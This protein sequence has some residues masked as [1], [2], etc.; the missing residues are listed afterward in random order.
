MDVLKESFDSE[1]SED[2]NYYLKIL[3]LYI[4]LFSSKY[5]DFD[6]INE[7]TCAPFKSITTNLLFS[8]MIATVLNANYEID[9]DENELSTETRQLT[10]YKEDRAFIKKI[11]AQYLSYALDKFKEST[12]YQGAHSLFELILD[13]LAT[14]YYNEFS[15]QRIHPINLMDS[16]ISANILRFESRLYDT[17][18]KLENE[19]N[20]KLKLSHKTKKLDKAH[21]I[22]IVLRSIIEWLIIYSP[23]SILII[24]AY[25]LFVVGNPDVI[26]A[27]IS[28]IVTGVLISIPVVILG[29]ISEPIM[30]ILII[31]LVEDILEKKSSQSSSDL[32]KSKIKVNSLM[33]QCSRLNNDISG[34][35]KSLK[36]VQEKIIVS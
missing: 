7:D 30:K 14:D 26:G 19:E 9:N 11:G 31:G 17:K 16:S 29:I 22:I 18:L 13:L 1:N 32:Y 10:I 6:E 27:I 12:N 4:K 2:E 15:E 36:M 21:N 5:R 8:K 23:V 24:R 33:E 28:L 3:Y 20:I 34:L 35:K 25:K